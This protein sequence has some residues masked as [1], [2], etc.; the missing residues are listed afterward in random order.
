MTEDE[1]RSKD[2]R[3]RV[4][5][6]RN[7]ERVFRARAA[8]PNYGTEADRRQAFYDA[9]DCARQIEEMMK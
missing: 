6:L 5:L 7:N 9:E 2:S 8:N 3:R 1:F 4:E